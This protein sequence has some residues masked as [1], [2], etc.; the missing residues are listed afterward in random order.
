MPGILERQ[1]TMFSAV[2][3]VNMKAFFGHVLL[4][5]V[6]CL[7][8]TYCQPLKLLSDFHEFQYRI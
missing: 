8:V 7:P 4:F 5:F 2:Q 3:E 6:Y 1:G